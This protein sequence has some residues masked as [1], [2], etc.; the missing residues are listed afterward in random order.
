[1]TL[2]PLESISRGCPDRL[3]RLEGLLPG[4]HGPEPFELLI[5]RGISSSLTHPTAFDPDQPA[6]PEGAVV[7]T[8]TL[9]RAPLRPGAPEVLAGPAPL[10]HFLNP[11]AWQG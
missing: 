11:G 6:L 1:M 5:Y 10:D 7:E 8:V 4:P 3:L 2:A 9:L